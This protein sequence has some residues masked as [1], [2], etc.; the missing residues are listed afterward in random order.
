MVVRRVITVGAVSL[1][2]IGVLAGCS[3]SSTS[4]ATTLAESTAASAAGSATASG[5]TQMLPPVI[6]TESQTTT[7][8]KVGD[9]ID[10][11]VS[12]PAGTTIS[13]DKPD[14]LEVTQ[15]YDDGSAIFNP[16]AKALAPGTAIIT[17]TN[18]DSTTRD[19]TVTITAA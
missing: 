13:T 16:G 4:T 9:F 10:I 3:S 15:A 5:S 12:K 17:V 2:G 1:L 14:L 7:T 6:V 19:I 18:P 11:V 8:A